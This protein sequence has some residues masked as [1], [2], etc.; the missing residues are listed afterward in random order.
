MEAIRKT[1]FSL[2]TEAALTMGS[3]ETH[4]YRK[5]DHLIS[6]IVKR[7][8][9]RKIPNADGFQ[10][11]SKIICPRRDDF[12]L[13]FGVCDGSIPININNGPFD[14]IPFV[15]RHWPN[16]SDDSFLL[17]KPKIIALL[18]RKMKMDETKP[19][20]AEDVARLVH[21]LLLT[22]LFAPNNNQSVPWHLL[23]YIDRLDR[24]CSYDW[25]GYMLEVLLDGIRKA[26][27]LK[28]PGCSVFLMVFKRPISLV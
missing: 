25:C 6:E 15:S 9:A 27:S 17:V 12:E 19:N 10:F 24:I 4:M 7:A 11:G 22:V 3:A 21:M 8:V 18:N 28:V 1:P 16:R 5:S 26:S 2:F 14:T 13:I 20:V 23:R